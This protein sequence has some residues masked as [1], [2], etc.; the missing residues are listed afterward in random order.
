MTYSVEQFLL[1][2]EARNYSPHSLRA[3]R[4][5]LGKFTTFIQGR[6]INQRELSGFTS[7][8]HSSGLDRLSIVR[9]LA[10]LKSYLVWAEVEGYIP[11]DNSDAVVKGKRPKRLP[12]VP[13]VEEVGHLLDGSFEC[14]RDKAICELLYATGIRA[15]EL[16]GIN[17][18]DFEGDRVIL[19]RGKG[20]KERKVIFG[21]K[22]RA[23]LVAWFDEREEWLKHKQLVTEALFF[24]YNGPQT[25]RID[26]RNIRRIIKSYATDRGF[27]ADVW[28]THVLRH[29]FA[30]HCLDRGM[31]LEAISQL[32]GHAK[33]ST[34]VHYTQVATSRMLEAY[35]EAHPHGSKKGQ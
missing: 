13:S 17:M 4:S 33:L 22:A 20:Q 6:E 30:C 26:Q 27:N 18:P 29:A 31:S 2:L 15:D 34:T 7:S 14:A 5:D 23:A 35:S 21:A 19:V 12:D 11:G 3:Y 24:G 1:S 8:L 25:G 32:L 16:C 9:H 10:A 28:H